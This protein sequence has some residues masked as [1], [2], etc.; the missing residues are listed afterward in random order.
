MDAA[1]G[2]FQMLL[3]LAIAAVVFVP[4]LVLL[5]LVIRDTAR[6]SGRWGINTNPVRCPRCGERAPPRRKPENWR[7]ALW[8]GATCGQC[9]CEYD[10]W[11]KPVDPYEGL[12]P[13]RFR[14]RPPDE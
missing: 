10:K 14:R 4:L 11:G 6:G 5:E 7:E 1:P 9:G 8:G 2:W 13:D 3:A 12:D